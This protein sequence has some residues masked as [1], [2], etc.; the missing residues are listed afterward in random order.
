MGKKAD[1]K[2]CRRKEEGSRSSIGCVKC[3]A[4]IV[5]ITHVDFSHRN[6]DYVYPSSFQGQPDHARSTI[7][8]LT[9]SFVL[10]I[11]DETRSNRM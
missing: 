11:N 3:L 1:R 7:K 10:L 2:A 6:N 4:A 5:S 9:M 8:T